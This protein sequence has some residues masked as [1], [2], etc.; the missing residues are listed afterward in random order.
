NALAAVGVPPTA[1]E[2]RWLANRRRLW[3]WRPKED[4]NARNSCVVGEDANHGNIPVRRLPFTVYPFSH[5]VTETT[6]DAYYGH[7]ALAAVGVPP[8]AGESRWLANRR[9]LWL[10][11]PKE[12]A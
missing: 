6:V 8:T 4:A 5:G 3:L 12:D 1:G 9:R 10:W 2:S 7:N 11:R